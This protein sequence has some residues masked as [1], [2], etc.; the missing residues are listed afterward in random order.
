MQNRNKNKWLLALAAGLILISAW[1]WSH[2]TASLAQHS[3]PVSFVMFS[4]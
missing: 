2:E 1:T 4:E 3:S